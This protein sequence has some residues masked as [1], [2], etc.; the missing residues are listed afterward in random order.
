MV[1][2]EARK[3][4]LESYEPI[5]VYYQTEEDRQKKNYSWNRTRT[6][7]TMYGTL[8]IF[9]GTTTMLCQ[10]YLPQCPFR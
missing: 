10:K 6:Y 3:I 5:K 1:N 4:A 2:H 9:L 8:Y 7:S